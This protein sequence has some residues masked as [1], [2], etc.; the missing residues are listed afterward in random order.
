M[1]HNRRYDQRVAR[2]PEISSQTLQ[3][4]KELPPLTT[5][6]Y[7]GG[8]Y[9]VKKFPITTF[10]WL[11]GLM[12]MFLFSGLTPSEQVPTPHPNTPHVFGRSNAL[13]D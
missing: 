6:V 9:F 1:H 10:L 11:L 12:L 7:Q 5:A 3:Q 4:L 13:G 2:Q 8:K